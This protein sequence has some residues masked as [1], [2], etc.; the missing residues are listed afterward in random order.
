MDN[1]LG[2]G[3]RFNDSAYLGFFSR[4]VIFIL[5]LIV[6]IS[7]CSIGIYFNI[8]Q[9]V[10]EASDN[11]YILYAALF[12]SYLYLTIIK[13]S[14]I[15]TLGQIVTKSRILTIYGKRPSFIRMNFRLMF[16]A[17]GPINTL[18]DLVFLTF[19]REKRSLRD[20]YSDTIVVKKGTE[21]VEV[22]IPVYFTRIFAL[23]LNIMYR[24]CYSK[25]T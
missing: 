6:V 14:K 13:A 9:Q 4:L 3:V 24:S 19:I 18:S 8:G 15:G 25:N 7:I 2:L 22:D 5:D 16:W 11:N 20:C 17:I 23:G 12:L 1:E 21:P 10:G